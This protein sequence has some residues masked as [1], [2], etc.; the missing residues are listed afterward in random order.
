MS[1]RARGYAL[2]MRFYP[3][4]PSR[5]A[6]TLARDALVVILLVLLA[7]LAVKVHDA[8]DKLSVLGEGVRKVGDAVPVVGDPVADLGKRGEDGVHHFANVLALLVFLPP[9]LLLLWR[10][11]P[12]SVAQVRRLTAGARVLE[13]GDPRYV[14][15]RAAFSLPYGQLLEY[16]R[17]PLGDLAA[18]RYAPLVA[19]A[20]NDAGLRAPT[21]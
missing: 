14:A 19:A 21:S 5:R 10:Y 2:R 6:G 7:W 1:D 16:T 17:D 9:A 15:M 20:L 3:D 4:I 12:E 13:G 18:E 11:L 8:A